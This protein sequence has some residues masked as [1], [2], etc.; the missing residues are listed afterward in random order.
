MDIIVIENLSFAYASNPEIEVLKDINLRIQR[1]D[2]V[3]LC[4]PTGCGKTTLIE[5]LNGLVPHFH[6]GE[7]KGRIIVANKEV[8]YTPVHEMS[9][10]VGIVFQNPEN[11][12]I[13]M[14]VEKE[15]SFALENFGVDP[16][17]M[18]ERVDKVLRMLNIEDLRYKAPYDLSGGQ[19]QRVAIASIL[20]LNPDIIIF[21]EP[22][23]NLDPVSTIQILELINNLNKKYGKTIILIEH[24]LEM[25][26]KYVN[27]IVVMNEGKIIREGPPE[28]I[29]IDDKLENLGLR[30]PKIIQLYKLLIKNG[31]KL[32]KIPLTINDMAELLINL[33][34]GEND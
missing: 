24:R 18:R 27:K 22:T 7:I 33:V 14:N 3:L 20:T 15:L 13:S 2:F 31:F 26:L 16:I 21:D 17:E 34:E 19:Q 12:L 1:G 4:G 25:V 11:Q 5:C 6:S 23:S 28:Q 30:I 9:K 32:N 8:I 10:Y 29:I